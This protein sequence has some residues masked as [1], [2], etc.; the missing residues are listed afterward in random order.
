MKFDFCIT[1]YASHK[2][3]K[4]KLERTNS[5]IIESVEVVH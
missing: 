1:A 3:A 4:L 5:R 2:R